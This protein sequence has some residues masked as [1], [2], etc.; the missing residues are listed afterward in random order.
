MIDWLKFPSLTA[1]RS[2]EAT[3]RAGSFSEAARRL[4][5]TH[6]AVAQQIRA[7]EDYLGIQLLERSP[8]GV[9][10]TRDGEELAQT[11]YTGFGAIA[12]GVDAL[13]ER[14]RNRP[15]RITTTAFFAEAVIFPRMAEFW[16]AHSGT[17]ISFTPSDD[18]LDIVAE[19][20]DL[21]IRA[22]EGS[23]EGLSARLLVESPT[24][25]FAAPALI[26]DPETQW[27]TLPWLIPTDSFWEREALE[28]S[29]IDTKR[30]ATRDLGNPSLE[31]RAGEEGMGLVLESEID[32]QAQMRAGTLKIAPVPI[33]HVSRYFIVTPP[34]KPRQPVVD[35]ME[36]LVTVAGDA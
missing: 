17:A 30:I 4:N 36:W 8:R 13:L 25:A 7:L 24:R 33:N 18:A 11:L 3:A 15:I 1:L 6:A 21:A 20:F 9:S 32:M 27:D 2:F 31:V 19:G 29:G 5:V 28:Q 16:G 35:F 23:W 22:G 34:W 10:L 26:D 12:E 14:D